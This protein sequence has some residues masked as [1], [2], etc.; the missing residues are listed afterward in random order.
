MRI[1]KIDD[2]EVELEQVTKPASEISS[3]NTHALVGTVEIIDLKTSR[4]FAKN[5]N[6]GFPGGMATLPKLAFDA[7]DEQETDE[8]VAAT[9]ALMREWF[10]RT[11]GRKK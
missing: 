3:E 7:L 11:E 1:I 2:G 4:Q 9:T 5:L 10:Y 8:R 6:F